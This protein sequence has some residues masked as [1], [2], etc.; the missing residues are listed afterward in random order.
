MKDSMYMLEVTEAEKDLD[1]M[2][3]NNGRNKLQVRTSSIKATKIVF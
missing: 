3:A 1:E 2:I